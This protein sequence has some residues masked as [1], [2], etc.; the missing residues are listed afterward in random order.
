MLVST[1]N[2]TNLV[3][4]IAQHTEDT[5]RGVDGVLV[6]LVERIEVELATVGE[7]EPDRLERLRG[8]FQT[9]VKA[10][11]QLKGLSF[12]DADGYSIVN[13]QAVTQRLNFSDRDYFLHHHRHAKSDFLSRMSHELRT[14]RGSARCRSRR[15]RHGA[16]G[17]DEGVHRSMEGGRTIGAQ[18][19]RAAAFS[20]VRSCD[21]R[22]QT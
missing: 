5:I 3:R 15:Q 20:G 22:R 18:G 7:L 1:V 11:P 21:R 12:L 9:H 6:G 14:A 4:S 13:S 19:A 16:D 2:A 17:R 8:V 10:L